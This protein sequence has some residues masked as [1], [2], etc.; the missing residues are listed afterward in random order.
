[1]YPER[2][3]RKLVRFVM[4]LLVVGVL[5]AGAAIA[6]PALLDP[7]CDDYEWFGADAAQVVRQH[8][9]AAHAVIAQFIENVQDL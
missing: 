7:L 2:R 1:M 9:R 3:S 5:A 8:A 4:G 6:Y